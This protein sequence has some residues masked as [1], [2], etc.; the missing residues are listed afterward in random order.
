MNLS[1]TFHVVTGAGRGIGIAIAFELAR[2]GAAGVALVDREHPETTA[3]LAVAACNTFRAIPIAADVSSRSGVVTAIDTARTAFG[4]LDGIVSNAGVVSMNVPPFSAITET[5]QMWE[6]SINVNLMAHVWAAEAI[7]PSFETQEGGGAFVTIV[8]AAGLLTQIG[9]ASYSVSKAAALAYSESLTIH[10]GDRGVRVHCVCPQAVATALVGLPSES[11][12]DPNPPDSALAGGAA[13]GV[14]SPAA[15]AIA[16]CDAME[17]GTFL[18]LP[19]PAVAEYAAFKATAPSKW[20]RGM[21][22]LKDQMAAGLTP[23][24]QG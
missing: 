13:D 20:I 6:E 5:P 11:I 8:S 14:L 22:R 7:V 16:T 3:I 24:V 4:R 19:H 9:A 10:H 15:V 17:S 1:S 18:V 12:D 2:R 21:R 23:M